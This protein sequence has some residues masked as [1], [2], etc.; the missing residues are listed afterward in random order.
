MITK[1][2]SKSKP[3]NASRSAGK[4]TKWILAGVFVLI[5]FVATALVS[6][7]SY[8]SSASV[9][10]Q[11]RQKVVAKTGMDLDWRTL[12]FEFFPRPA[13]VIAEAVVQRPE[14]IESRIE[15]IRI[16]PAILP[17]F[18]GELHLATVRIHAPEVRVD[19]PPRKEDKREAQFPDWM[20]LVYIFAFVFGDT[21][22]E[23]ADIDVDLLEGQFHLS[24]G[25]QPL[26][27]LG[28]LD[29]HLDLA[30]QSRRAARASLKGG[31]SGV[32][33]WKDGRQLDVDTVWLDGEVVL[34]EDELRL[35]LDHLSLGEP[36][37]SLSGILMH[38]LDRP[39]VRL[40]LSG[41]DI[42]VEATRKLVLDVAGESELTKEIFGY[43]KGGLVE[44]ITFQSQ[45]RVPV[46]LGALA[47]FRI[48]GRLA[49]G[50]VS[51]PPLSLDLHDVY[52]E[53]SIVDGVLAGRNLTARLE[54]A[55]GK[56]G[57]LQIGLGSDNDIFMLDLLLE[58]DL[59]LSN[60][61]IVTA[62][63]DNEAFGRETERITNLQGAC[64]GRLTIGDSLEEFT[65]EVEVYELD[66]VAD[67]DRLPVS[68]TAQSGQ[69]KIVE[70][71]IEL[72]DLNGNIGRSQFSNL[73]ATIDY[74]EGLS[75]DIDTGPLVLVM[76]EIYPWLRSLPLLS[77]DLSHFSQLK[78]KVELFGLI[79]QGK[80]S[81]SADW[82]IETQGKFA[83]MLMKSPEWPHEIALLR[84]DFTID[85]KA[86]TFEGL[87]VNSGN[88][89][90][91]ASGSL[92]NYLVGSSPFS[93]SLD[94]TLDEE[95]LAWLWH[96]L[97]I[98]E[99]ITLRPP[100]K[101]SGVKVVQENEGRTLV[102]GDFFLEKGINLNLDLDY[103]DTLLAIKKLRVEDQHSA[104]EL[105][106]SYGADNFDVSYNGSLLPDTLSALFKAGEFRRS[107]IEGKI[108]LSTEKR[109]S[110]KGAAYGYLNGKHISIPI[111]VKEHAEI[112]EI[113]LIGEGT[114]VMAVL[115]SLSW[116]D[117]TWAPV[118]ASYKLRGG[119]PRLKVIK[120][121]ICGIDSPGTITFGD[122]G[123]ALDFSLQS[124][125]L[126]VAT[127]FS[128]LF[129][130]RVKMSGALDMS[131]DITSTGSVENLLEELRGPFRLVF[132]DGVV[133]EGRTLAKVLEVLNVTEIFRGKLP[134]F[135]RSGL[136][137]SAIIFEG[138]LTEG[139]AYIDTLFMDGKTL[140]IAGQGEIDLLAKTI[141]MNLMAAPFKTVDSIVKLIPGV[142]YLFGGN[143]I[144]LPLSIEGGLDDPQVELMSADSVGSGLRRLWERTAQS[145]SKLLDL[146]TPD[147]NN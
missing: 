138:R 59:S 90:I 76:D 121:E 13:L 146:L 17:L 101:L 143:L 71:R 96:K 97:Q 107:R 8:L 79:F 4:K 66:F 130:Q 7:N 43:L 9:K 111:S 131:S 82:R 118:Q 74:T 84:G 115:S 129:P 98:P 22:K 38:R 127:S 60:K 26:L 44:E 147:G 11:I 45:G 33:L 21:A 137:Y 72:R 24:R 109:E 128:C 120:A 139:K 91:I 62:I 19:L 53:V 117:H 31:S 34:S 70:N 48:D 42:N 110:V 10:Q 61:K 67:Y 52:G 5:V 78:G 27:L 102:K 29:L 36:D 100:V 119:Q 23:I 18:M 28:G 123:I 134:N 85:S 65:A 15:K 87:E 145:P 135:N 14:S 142:N 30:V 49:Q 105:E 1:M 35:D 88:S 16:A 32:E 92:P 83:N 51:V 20:E 126:D 95:A 141:D 104:A 132:R 54:D 140:E 108:S 99:I 12:S 58:A 106:L 55:M 69:A 136:A 116:Q 56:E 39:E 86:L 89:R 81:E 37:V 46:D 122:N 64:R 77:D 80:V 68:I 113:T 75:L 40:T 114:Q 25:G 144:A 94:G 50:A 125:A 133:E 112:D 47:N 3:N 93:T 41:K 2:S 57:S 103:Q 73:A 6:M 63:V 124:K